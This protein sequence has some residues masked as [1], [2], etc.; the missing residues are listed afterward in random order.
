MKACP[1]LGG[2]V[3]PSA[4]R[5]IYCSARCRVTA[6]WRRRS[7]RPP[8]PVAKPCEV[9]DDEERAEIPTRTSYI[10]EL[11]RPPPLPWETERA[12][13]GALAAA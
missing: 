3:P 10:N 12:P 1:V 2:K 4:Q 6:K 9:A 7:K 13:E 8:G 5:R 11:L